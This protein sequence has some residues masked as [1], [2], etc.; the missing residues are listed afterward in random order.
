MKRLF[1]FFSLT[2]MFA[3]LVTQMG[4]SSTPVHATSSGLT[5]TA[6]SPS[7]PS[8]WAEFGRLSGVWGSSAND[9]YAVGYGEDGNYKYMPLLY[10]YDKSGWTN[11]SLSL[12]SGWTAGSLSGVWG[13][14]ASDVYAVGDGSHPGNAGSPLIYHNGGSGWTAS[15]PSLPSGWDIGDLMGV[16][17]SSASN[18][19]AVG[20]GFS[21]NPGPTGPLPLIYY[22]G[23]SGWSNITPSLPSGWTSGQL[24]GV[25]ASSTTSD[26]YAVGFGNNGTTTLPLLYH[27]DG[28]G[29]TG[30]S[31]SMGSG[32][33]LGQLFSVW[34]SS[35]S[36][37]YAVGYGDDVP[38]IYHYDGSGWTNDSPSLPSG[39]SNSFLWGVWGSSGSDIYAFG[40]GDRDLAYYH[41]DGNSWTSSKSSPSLPSGW[42]SSDWGGVWGSSA[43]DVYAIGSGYNST[44]HELPLIYH[45]TP[46]TQSPPIVTAFAA[47][48]PTN[49]PNIP[50]TS[51]TASDDGGVTGYMIT[52]SS[53][54]PL[55]TDPNWLAS[56]PATYPV[57]GDGTYTLYPWA[58]DAAGNVSAVYGSPAV[59]IVNTTTPVLVSPAS[60][61]KV[62]TFRPAFKWLAVTGYTK[63]RIE[64]SKYSNF[65][66]PLVNATVTALSYTPTVNLPANTKLYWSVRIVRPNGTFGALTTPYYFT[67]GLK[68]PTLTT[69]ANLV[70]GVAHKPTFK[71]QAVSGATSYTIQ[72]STSSTFGTFL[73]NVKIGSTTYIS[74]VTLPG[75]KV[76]YWRVMATG[77]VGSSPWSSV[78]HFTTVP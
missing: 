65:A 14:S 77:A 38:L 55:S 10:H 75:N 18:I 33:T 20:C 46:G 63:Y 44:G 53:A 29:W 62:S 11:A 66:S 26:V 2:I 21:F 67:I 34:G 47:T 3:L 6:F 72:V 32:R 78:F 35:A 48:S 41:Y 36:D 51:F 70:T 30:S 54:A 58:K 13:S 76:L 1:K 40:N 16:W 22:Y 31:P 27:Y 71:W 45:G 8:G 23:G 12:P 17:G 37:I 57:A 74:T 43:S 42:T 39:W 25:W 73:I 59:V 68:A 9:V 24:E 56:A 61:S 5:F 19:Y 7:L 64:V 50:I 15:S 69:P 28:S 49:N 60:G 4:F 52:A